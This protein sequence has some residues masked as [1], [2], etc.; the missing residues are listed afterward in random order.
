MFK[1]WFALLAVDFV[2]LTWVGAMPTEG[3]Y[4]YIALI[5]ST[6]WFGYFLVIL[7]LLGVIEKPLKQPAT[8]EDDF[9]AH[10]APSAQPAE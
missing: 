6:Y 7:P 9:N 5:A 1:W 10:H 8:I 2:V 4:P 3:I